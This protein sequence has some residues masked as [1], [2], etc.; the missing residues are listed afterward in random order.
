M[1]EQIVRRINGVEAEASKEVDDL[2]HLPR[3]VGAVRSFEAGYRLIS[4]IRVQLFGKD[5]TKGVQILL[6]E[7][8]PRLFCELRLGF[9]SQAKA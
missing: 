8:R 5:R 2:V 9:G 4:T 3:Q 6:G 1:H 7:Y